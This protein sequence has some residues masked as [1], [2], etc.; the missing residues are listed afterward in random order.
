MANNSEDYA[1]GYEEG[2][3]EGCENTRVVSE[4]EY[5]DGFEDGRI[6]IIKEFAK[7]LDEEKRHGIAGHDVQEWEVQKLLKGVLPWKEE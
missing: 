5:D 4:D 3:E 6:S 7:W 2:Y 1:I